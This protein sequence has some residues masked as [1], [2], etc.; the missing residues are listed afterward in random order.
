M[1]PIVHFTSF[2]R[3]AWPNPLHITRSLFIQTEPTPNEDSLIF[4][5][6]KA[7]IQGSATVEFTSAQ[8]AARKS[9]LAANL[10]DI[11]GVKSVLFGSDFISVNKRSDALWIHLKPAIFAAI[12]DQ[13]TIH[14]NEPIIQEAAES[15]GVDSLSAAEEDSEVVKAI[16]EI[17]E[18]RVRPVIQGDGGDLEYCGF[19]EEAGVVKLKLQGACR[20][21]ASSVVTLKNGIQNMLMFYIPEVKEVIQVE[22]ETEQASEA[23]FKA[24]EASKKDAN[25]KK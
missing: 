15:Q 16:K 1:R 2:S 23:A 9:K 12:M 3:S 5:P 8:Q 18:T 17:L 13:Y 24:F 21:C 7:V 19:D 14:A 4:R 20:S 6:G 10:F 25:K 11:E 22:D